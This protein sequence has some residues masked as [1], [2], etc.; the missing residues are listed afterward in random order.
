MNQAGRGIFLDDKRL[1]TES[2]KYKE[3]LRVATPSVRQKVVN[4]SG[5]NQQKV[6]F[7]RW[8]MVNPRIMIVDEPTR[9]VDVG[10]KA[11]I[12]Q[13]LREMT[14]REPVS[15]L[16]PQICRRLCQSVIAY[17]LCTRAKLPESSQGRSYGGSDYASCFRNSG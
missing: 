15:S 11:E 5:G 1:L 4:L 14:K 16:Y 9:G 17:M 12:Y 2:E 7:A 8:L 10:A 13:I 3:Q 6:V